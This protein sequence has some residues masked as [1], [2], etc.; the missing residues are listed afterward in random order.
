MK[1]E[2]SYNAE[3][4]SEDTLKH[5]QGSKQA[6]RAPEEY[7]E[8]KA[9][10]LESAMKQHFDVPDEYFT[11]QSERLKNS[12]GNTSKPGYNRRVVQLWISLAAAAVVAG[13]IFLVIP[14]KRDAPSF[15]EQ[16]NSSELEFEDL[17]Q[18]D[19][20]EE[21]YE[22]FVIADTLVEDSVAIS[23]M[24]AAVDEFKP[25]KGQSVISWEDIDAAD[26]EEYLK[27]EETIEIID[28]L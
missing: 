9:V 11:T 3:G 12:L 17:E 1:R 24:P 25:S 26:I 18:I 15:S 28:E 27:E 7:F 20:D 13:V 19:F 8:S 22:E 10:L 21:V 4:F 2:T 23:K 5:L 14:V 16:L 6:L